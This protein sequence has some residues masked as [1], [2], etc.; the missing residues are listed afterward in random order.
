MA[1]VILFAHGAGAPST[2]AWMRA[3]KER[4]S[5][6]GQVETFDYPYIKES[7][8]TPDRQPV[9]IA[10][11]RSALEAARGTRGGRAKVVLAGKSMGSRIGCHVA[12][13]A[14]DEVDALVCFGYPLRS[15]S[16][17]KSRAEVL[18]AL[19]H[20]VL[21][22]QGSRD[23]LCPLDELESV[24]ARM[25]APTELFVVEGGNH[26]LEIG[27]RALFAQGHTQEEVDG[28]IMTAVTAFLR[29]HRIIRRS[30]TP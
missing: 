6:A 19:T 13:E 10:A 12:V 20:P 15:G 26:S 3:W 30:S 7:R 29:A 14:P 24:I 23:S 25:D 5:A 11:H 28:S 16:T 9:L 21:F 27:K 17:G 1:P 2:S 22:V 4:L 18:L 8:K